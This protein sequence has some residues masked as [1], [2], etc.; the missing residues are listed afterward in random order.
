MRPTAWFVRSALVGGIAWA[1]LAHAQTPTAIL[2]V[3]AVIPP[4]CVAGTLDY[5][6]L[7][8]G[9][10]AALDNQIQ[11]ASGVGAGTIQVTCVQGLSYTIKL[12]GGLNADGSQRYMRGPANERILYQLFSDAQFGVPWNIG[13][14]VNQEGS[15]LMQQIPL[16]GRVPPQATPAAGVY[17]DT[18]S[19]TVEW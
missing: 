6:V 8:F 13:A 14:V 19:V 12:D 7:D 10:H 5:G 18:V 11:V 2:G 15:G 16:Y 17:R 1:A 4:A 3:R 9:S